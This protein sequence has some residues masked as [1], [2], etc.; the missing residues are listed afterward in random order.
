MTSSSRELVHAKSQQAHQSLI[1][2]IFRVRPALHLSKGMCCLDRPFPA[3]TTVATLVLALSASTRE[4]T[5]TGVSPL[6]LRPIVRSIPC[7]A[8]AGTIAAK[9]SSPSCVPPKPSFSRFRQSLSSVSARAV[10]APGPNGFSPSASPVSLGQLGSAVRMCW[11]DAAVS[12]LHLRS[13]STRERP[14]VLR[15][16]PMSTASSSPRRMLA[17]EILSTLCGRLLSHRAVL[18]ARCKASPTSPPAIPCSAGFCAPAR[19]LVLALS[20]LLC[21]PILTRAWCW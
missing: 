4:V 12:E 7:P 19:G 2:D 3:N 15:K 6:E 16:S 9:P 14:L 21:C 13:S 8:R 10:P 17:I 18:C 11:R 5:E 1:Y 20:T